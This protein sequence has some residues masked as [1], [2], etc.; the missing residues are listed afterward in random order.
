[1][2]LIF[3]SRCAVFEGQEHDYRTWNV[4]IY[5]FQNKIFQILQRRL[6]CSSCCEAVVLSVKSMW[7]FPLEKL[8]DPIENHWCL[9]A[10]WG[11]SLNYGFVPFPYVCCI[12]Y[13]AYRMQHIICQHKRNKWL[14]L[15]SSTY[16]KNN[17]MKQYECIID[18][19]D[20]L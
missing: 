17:M 11:Y 3:R 19:S 18:L 13:A 16:S 4:K 2:Q 1:M 12:R 5:D 7:K 9:Q 6:K 8:W 14:S 20:V 10:N 15:S